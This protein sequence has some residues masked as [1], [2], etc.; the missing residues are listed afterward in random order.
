MIQRHAEHILQRILDPFPLD[1]FLDEV[2]GKRFLKIQAKNAA[3]LGLLG[4]DPETAV[5]ADFARVAHKIGFHAAAPTGPA[6][7][8][9]PAPSAAAFKAMVEA[10]HDRGFTVRV[11]EIRSATPALDQF[12]RALEC[13]LHQPAA[14]EVFWSRGDGKAPAHHD[15]YD[16]IMIQIVGRKRW[17]ISTDPSDLPNTWRGIPDGPPRLDRYE[18]VLI[19]PGDFLY[20]P[21]G[22]VHRVDALADSMHISIGFSPLTLREAIIAC[23]DHLSDGERPLRESVG[24]RLPGQVRR[25]DF[26]DLPN[27][28]RDGLARLT[29]LCQS[30]AAV[31]D[32]LLRRSSRAIADLDRLRAK[33]IPADAPVVTAATRLRHNPLAVS[34]LI[35]NPTRIDFAYPGGHHYIHRGAEAA[36]AFI[37]NTPE[38]RIHDIPGAFGHDVRLA[39][40]EKFVTSGFL[41][42]V[43]D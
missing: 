39:L 41:E 12:M 8:A 20:L 26:D 4:D 36:V 25:L 10:F 19:E 11:P 16:I 34:H 32:A 22:T 27:Q 3:R 23:L 28:I 14:A 5:L 15:D 42:I 13:V 9:D 17:F 30:D 24:A 7:R 33:P 6:P 40:V 38:F 29:A 1:A 35:G 31:T 21:R 37:A 2:L 43:E 18:E